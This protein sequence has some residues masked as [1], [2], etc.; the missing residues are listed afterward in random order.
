MVVANQSESGAR[1]TIFQIDG[2]NSKIGLTFFHKFYNHIV[3]FD[4][5]TRIRFRIVGLGQRNRSM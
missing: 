1:K 2:E 5:Y 3:F 4:C